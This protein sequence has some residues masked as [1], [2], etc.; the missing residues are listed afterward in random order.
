[1]LILKYLIFITSGTLLFLFRSYI[2]LAY[3]WDVFGQLF[4]FNAF[5]SNYDYIVGMFYVLYIILFYN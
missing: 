4:S 5:K 3:F 2:N 1:M